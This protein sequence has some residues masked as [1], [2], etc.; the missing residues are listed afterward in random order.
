M[1]VIK[2]FIPGSNQ[3]EDVGIKDVGEGKLVS[4]LAP[5]G[6][7]GC[8]I[9]RPVRKRVFVARFYWH[10]CSRRLRAM[11]TPTCAFTVWT[12]WN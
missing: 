7:L 9:E 12:G 5:N 1:S 6:F 3:F 2:A 10:R 8:R 11:S 4:D